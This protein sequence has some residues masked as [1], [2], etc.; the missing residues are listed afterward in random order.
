MTVWPVGKQAARDILMIEDGAIVS[1]LGG[2]GELG[3]GL[4]ARSGRVG[5][6]EGVARRRRRG[7]GRQK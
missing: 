5:D 1:P 4:G 2:G 7:D 3:G 6:T